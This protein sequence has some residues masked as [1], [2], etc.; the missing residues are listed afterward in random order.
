MTTDKGAVTAHDRMFKVPRYTSSA[1]ESYEVIK[2]TEHFV[3]YFSEWCGKKYERRE[4][5]HRPY[6]YYSPFNEFVGRR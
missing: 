2:T 4:R 1:I 6:T 3:F 5:P